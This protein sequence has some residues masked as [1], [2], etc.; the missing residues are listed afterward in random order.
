VLNVG[1]R[2]APEH[3]FPTAVHDAQDAYQWLLSN[4]PAH[5]IDSRRIA[6]GGDSAGGT[7]ATG[8]T[9]AAR[10][11]G[12]PRPVFQT[13]LY[14]CTSAWQDTDSHRSLA[15]GY[16]LE[17]PTLQWMFSNYLTSERDRTDWRFAPLEASDL[18]GLAPAFIALAEYDPLM[19]EGI[20]YASRLKEAGVPIQLKIYEGMTHDF[21]RLTNIVNDASKVREEVAQQ[22]RGAF[23]APR[24]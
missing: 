1:Y 19:D 10:E 11:I 12:W 17:A 23:A 14:P 16:L 24:T 2:L 3:P 13:L 21:A 15:K 9:I 4:G 20:E 6:V 18:T 22:L 8:L 7:L 5:G